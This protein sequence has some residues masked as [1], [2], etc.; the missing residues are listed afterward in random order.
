[1]LSVFSCITAHL[2]NFL[3]ETAT[4]SLCPLKKKKKDLLKSSFRFTEKLIGVQFPHTPCHAHSP[5]SLT[6]NIPHQSG[7]TC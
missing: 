3:G 2:Y 1:M 5:A 4:Q 7:T 6:I